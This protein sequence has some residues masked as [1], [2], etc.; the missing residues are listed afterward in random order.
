MKLSDDPCTKWSYFLFFGK[1]IN[2]LAVF[3]QLLEPY[4]EKGRFIPM[5]VQIKVILFVCEVTLS[6][7]DNIF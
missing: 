7:I 4:K 5:T 6:I 3:A 1:D 2:N